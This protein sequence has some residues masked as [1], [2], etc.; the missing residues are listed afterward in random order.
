[1]LELIGLVPQDRLPRHLLTSRAECVVADPDAGET[2]GCALQALLLA[3]E[4]QDLV[5]IARYA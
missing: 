5:A 4:E 2:A 1:M 3:L